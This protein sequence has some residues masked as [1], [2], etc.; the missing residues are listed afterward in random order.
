MKLI[1]FWWTLDMVNFF[2]NFF[3][4]FICLE[5]P[6]A[7]YQQI[8]EESDETSTT[9]SKKV[10]NSTEPKRKIKKPKLKTKKSAVCSLLPKKKS[11]NSWVGT[12]RIIFIIYKSLRFFN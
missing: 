7:K 9:I 5:D 11:M 8:V 1:L 2:L 6:W 4:I 10:E 3:I 12:V